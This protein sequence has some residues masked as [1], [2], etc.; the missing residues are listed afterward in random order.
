MLK[1]LSDFSLNGPVNFFSENVIQINSEQPDTSVSLQYYFDKKGYLFKRKN[2]IKKGANKNTVIYD[3]EYNNNDLIK[4]TKT[5]KSNKPDHNDR[6]NK[7]V[8]IYQDNKVVK[9]TVYKEDK[10]LSEKIYKYHKNDKFA[11]IHEKYIYT[12]KYPPLYDDKFLIPESVKE[13]F[14]KIQNEYL[15]DISEFNADGD[16]ILEKKYNERGNLK[17]K[18]TFIYNTKGY[19]IEKNIFKNEKDIETKVLMKYDD[20][21]RKIEK[22]EYNDKGILIEEEVSKYDK[23]GN[24]IEKTEYWYKGSDITVQMTLYKYSKDNQLIEMVF[25]TT[26]HNN[27]L[28]EE[29]Y[30]FD[31]VPKQKKDMI[32]TGEKENKIEYDYDMYGNW[33][34]KRVFSINA[35]KEFILKTV[36]SRVIKYYNN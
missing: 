36:L 9:E 19:L 2:N 31:L 33:I 4:E 23:N 35:K 5:S 32:S 11:A 14:E 30:N 3:F 1:N 27:N 7:T 16:L 17:T 25:L 10:I 22:K 13:S 26:D 20:V 18:K 34:T 29:K 21:K 28:K 12:F 6:K 24:E 15:K 8:S